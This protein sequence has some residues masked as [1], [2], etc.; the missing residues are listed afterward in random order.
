MDET[1]MRRAAEHAKELDL[2][3]TDHAENHAISANGVLNEGRVSRILDVRGVPSKAEVDI[4]V[5]DIDLARKIG[6]RIHLQHISTKE[7]L[8]LIREAKR[9]KLPI[10]AET[11]PHYFSL[12][13][14][15]VLE[16]AANAKMNPPL[17]TENDRQAVIEALRDGTI[18]AIATDHAPHA[19]E[20]KA[21]PL[22][23]APFG[24]VGLE[25]AFAISYTQLVVP[26][27]LTLLQLIRLM[28]TSPSDILG[29]KG[30]G[31]NVGDRADIAVFDVDNSYTIDSNS[32]VSK[33]RNT[34]F[35]GM[36]VYGRAVL[37]V[38][39]GKITHL[40]QK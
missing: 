32:F 36:K 31:L 29:W 12:T 30:G 23:Q 16:H 37:S 35:N 9:Q 24:V 7:S 18:D 21:Q 19:P 6:C 2:L 25:T 15:A 8:E 22:E 27:Y 28:S 14:E 40:S 17:R 33:G 39:K 5:R 1:L 10:T 26:G 3:I 20:E 34:P 4:V 11:A 38:C 13:E